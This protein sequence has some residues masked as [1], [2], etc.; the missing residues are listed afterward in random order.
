MKTKYRKVSI[1]IWNDDKFR[2]FHDDQKLLFFFLL[3]HPYQTSVGGM[4]GTKLGIGSELGWK[5]ERVSKGFHGPIREGMVWVDETAS[6]IILPNFVKHNEPENPNVVKGW[7]GALDLIPDCGIKLKLIQRLTDY[8]STREEPLRKAFETVSKGFGKS[9]RTPEPEPEP[10]P[11]IREEAKASSTGAVAVSPESLHEIYNRNRGTLPEC[12][13]LSSGRRKKC[14]TR[15]SSHKGDPEFPKNFETSILRA[16]LNGF[17]NGG[18]ERKWIASFDWFVENDENYLKVLEG[19]YDGTSNGQTKESA[20]QR[21]SREATE[22]CAAYL[23][24]GLESVAGDE[25][26]ARHRIAYAGE[27]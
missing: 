27:N 25:Q 22:A 4:R 17:C 26:D 20:A 2:A 19:K 5:A 24:E 1:Q 9:S 21:R 15:I 16:S 6:C 18:G 14:L 8:I 23:G 7:S 11:Y 3:T 13:S 12:R 10:E